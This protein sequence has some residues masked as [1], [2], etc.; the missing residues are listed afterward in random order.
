M[1]DEAMRLDACELACEML[2]KDK[3]QL[4]TENKRLHKMLCVKEVVDAESKGLIAALEDKN[5]KLKE[6]IEHWKTHSDTLGFNRTETSRNYQIV[7][8]ENTKLKAEVLRLQNICTEMDC[9]QND[10]KYPDER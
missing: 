5:E 8:T 1:E 2:R 4:E 3:S 10:I 6:A 7:V 9:A